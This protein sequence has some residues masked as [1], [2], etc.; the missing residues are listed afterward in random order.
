MRQL[1]VGSLKFDQVVPNTLTAEQHPASSNSRRVSREGEVSSGK[2]HRKRV[3]N[4]RG[5]H[6]KMGLRGGDVEFRGDEIRR[7]W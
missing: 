6:N 2:G 7:Q 5:Y 1:K 3:E 4:A